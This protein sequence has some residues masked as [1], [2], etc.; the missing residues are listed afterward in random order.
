MKPHEGLLKIFGP[1]SEMPTRIQ[2]SLQLPPIS[3]CDLRRDMNLSKGGTLL[4]LSPSYD[5]M[6]NGSVQTRIEY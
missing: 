3:M 1:W 4:E 2:L 5:M 6:L